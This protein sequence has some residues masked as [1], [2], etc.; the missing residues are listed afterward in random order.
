MNWKTVLLW[1]V[2]TQR[3]TKAVLGQRQQVQRSNRSIGRE[4]SFL[5]GDKRMRV[6]RSAI[7]CYTL[8]SPYDKS[9]ERYVVRT[10]ATCSHLQYNT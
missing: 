3:T 8:F 7:S 10:K 4:A 5:V 2:Y 1:N 6:Q 9:S